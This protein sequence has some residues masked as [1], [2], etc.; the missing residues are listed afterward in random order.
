MLASVLKSSFAIKA[1]IQVVRA[2]VQ[3]RHIVDANQSL[4]RKVDELAEQVGDHRKAIAIIFQ[5]LESMT[6]GGDSEAPKE[7][8]GFKT[9]K[10]RGISG[11]KKPRGRG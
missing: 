3:F 9:N 10:E 7:R 11:T 4:A 6:K 5:E 8:I 1:S 2:F